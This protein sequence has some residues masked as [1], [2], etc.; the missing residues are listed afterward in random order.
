MAKQA[1][2]EE[3]NRV[4]LLIRDPRNP[5]ACDGQPRT[6]IVSLMDRYPT[7]CDL[8]GVEIPNGVAG[9]SLRSLLESSQSA[10]VHTSVL[11]TYQPGNHCLRTPGFRLTQYTDGGAELYDMQ[12]DPE[13]RHNLFTIESKLGA[14]AAKLLEILKQRVANESRPDTSSDTSRREEKAQQRRA[15]NAAKRRAARQADKP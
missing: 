3:A 15:K 14:E 13:Q 4:Q 8:A 10:E 2:W 9:E 12:Q 1:L 7:L 6:Q 5:H 11:M